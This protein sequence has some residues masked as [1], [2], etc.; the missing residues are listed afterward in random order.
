M[1]GNRADRRFRQTSLQGEN[2]TESYDQ[3]LAMEFDLEIQTGN[4]SLCISDRWSHDDSVQV[5]KVMG[6]QD[7]EVRRVHPR[8][9]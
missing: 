1:F 6:L 8:P 4:F 9:L 5:P 7:H 2:L 3:R